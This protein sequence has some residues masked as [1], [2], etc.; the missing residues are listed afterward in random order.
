MSCPVFVSDQSVG[1]LEEVY[2]NRARSSRNTAPSTESIATHWRFDKKPNRSDSCPPGI[3]IRWECSYWCQPSPSGTSRRRS[4]SDPS[5]SVCSRNKPPPL[6]ITKLSRASAPITTLPP[7][8]STSCILRNPPHNWMTFLLSHWATSPV[9]HW[10]TR[11]PC[12]VLKTS[13]SRAP[14]PTF[15]N[16]W[17]PALYPI[18]PQR[19]TLYPAQSWQYALRPRPGLQLPTKNEEG[20]EPKSVLI[21]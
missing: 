12:P 3:F 19:L 16:P 15:C 13:W 7:R 11:S 2:H 14:H 8:P 21:G 4:S 6:L 17:R 1:T 18:P 5:S 10:T 9:S 20:E